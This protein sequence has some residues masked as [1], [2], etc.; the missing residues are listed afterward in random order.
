VVSGGRGALILVSENLHLIRFKLPGN[1]QRAI[2]RAVI[3]DYDL[4]GRPGLRDR[5]TE[6]QKSQRCEQE[7]GST[8][9]VSS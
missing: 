6:S 1:R 7:S 4:L 9:T 8:L 2:G 5:G 3:D